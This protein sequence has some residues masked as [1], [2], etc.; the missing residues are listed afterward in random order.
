MICTH[1]LQRCIR[2]QKLHDK[3][4]AACNLWAQFFAHLA[5]VRPAL[6]WPPHHLLSC[7]YHLRHDWRLRQQF[8]DLPL[9]VRYHSFVLGTLSILHRRH[10]TAWLLHQSLDASKLGLDLVQVSFTSSR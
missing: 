5:N 10:H 4:C 8:L 3:S 1:H 6:P 9:Q 7:Q 2:N